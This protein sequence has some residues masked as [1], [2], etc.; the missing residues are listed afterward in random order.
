MNK[1]YIIQY[2]NDELNQDEREHFRKHLNQD[3]SLRAEFIKQKNLWAMTASRLSSEVRVNG[4]ETESFIYGLNSKK[5]EAQKALRLL[6]KLSVYKIAA[7]L[8]FGLLVGNMVYMLSGQMSS[9][10]QQA[11]FYTDTYVPKGEKSELTLP[12]GTHIF[13]NADTRLR[14]PSNFSANNRRVWIEGEAYFNVKSDLDNP[15]LVETTSINIEVLGTSFDLSCY[16]D[17]AIVTTVLDEGSIRF[18]GA[19]NL[20]VNGAMLEPGET[21]KYHKESG[22][23]KIEETNDNALASSWKQGQLK[24]KDMPFHE[25]ALK[26]ERLYNV[27]I[28]VDEALKFERYTGEINSET[29]WAVMNHFAIATPFNVEAKG[30]KIKVTAKKNFK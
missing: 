20:K 10:T 19:N 3:A 23:F 28:E 21:A 9:E 14:V 17:D 1:A 27:E 8:M 11:I 25:L 6:K 16:A 12:D 5:E 15:F 22:V 18:S 4:L 26:I 24:F 2:L 29:V 30:R 13:V 7:I